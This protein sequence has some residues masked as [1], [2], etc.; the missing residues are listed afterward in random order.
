[1]MKTRETRETQQTQQTQRIRRAMLAKI[2]I[3][4]KELGLKEEEYYAILERYGVMTAA[5]LNHKELEELIKFFRFL[6]WQAKPNA[7]IKALRQRVMDKIATI[8]N[9]EN[10]LAGLVKK[11]CGVERLDW[12]RS[13]TTL[14][15]LIAVITKIS[16]G[17]T[18]NVGAQCIA[19]RRY[20]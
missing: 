18:R 12:C 6:G 13:V 15:R 2:H 4:K 9:G 17:E 7:Q 11:I 1:M 8:Q 3:A 10:R 19:P 5:D 16:E 20:K 14:E